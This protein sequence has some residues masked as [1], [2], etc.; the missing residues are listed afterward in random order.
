MAE[1]HILATDSATNQNT[2]TVCGSEHPEWVVLTVTHSTVASVPRVD[3]PTPDGRPPDSRPTG[4]QC[5]QDLVA[6]PLP[7]TYSWMKDD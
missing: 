1:P 5:V 7:D 6:I 2:F 4:M 3:V